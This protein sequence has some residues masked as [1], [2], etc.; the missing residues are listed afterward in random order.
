MRFRF[1]NLVSVIG[2]LGFSSV[3]V[4]VDRVDELIFTAQDAEKGF[5][6]L[7]SILIDLPLLETP[8]IAFKFFLWDQTKPFYQEAGGR[9][10]RLLEYTLEWSEAELDKVL[11]R[12]ME[13]YSD[14]KI[15]RLDQLIEEDSPYDV[16][17][18]VTYFANGSPRDMVRIC[19]KI[20]DEHTRTGSFDKIIAFRTV[21]SAI[22]AFSLERSTELYG[23]SIR[24]L[25]KVD[26]L[27][28]TINMLA[29]DIF[30]ITTQAARAK[31]QNWQLS[32]AVVRIGDVPNP[33]NR[34]LYLFGIRDP[35]LALAVLSES[36]LEEALEQFLVICP[37][38]SKLRVATE[39]EITCPNCQ[40]AFEAG[41]A[42]TLSSLCMKTAS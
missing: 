22:L 26:T 31:I 32:G 5:D 15:S 20:V 19:K 42:E 8:G 25:R 33:G 24:D 34:P 29:N 1:E 2:K 12:R 35:R 7:K 40:G 30:R 10:D 36:S 37:H 3:Y 41:E 23:E 14:K 6:F 13:T 11:S 9:S 16:H 38:C 39:G 27:A 21:K 18:L 17:K 28:F 4:L